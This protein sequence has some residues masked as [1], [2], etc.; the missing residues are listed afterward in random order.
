M[1]TLEREK[2][3]VLAERVEQD[4]GEQIEALYREIPALGSLEEAMDCCEDKAELSYLAAICCSPEDDRLDMFMASRQ[5]WWTAKGIFWVLAECLHDDPEAR[6]KLI[7]EA[8]IAL[9]REARRAMHDPNDENQEDTWYQVATMLQIMASDIPVIS[10]VKPWHWRKIE[11]ALMAE[12]FQDQEGIDDIQ[13]H[14]D[15]M[16]RRE[17]AKKGA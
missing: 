8:L 12:G 15:E 16:E 3:R 1:T 6:R 13:R 7:F 5:T 14:M 2:I 10:G 9:H 4:V 11:E 17:K